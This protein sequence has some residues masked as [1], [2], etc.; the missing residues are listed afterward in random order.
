M[1]ETV[2]DEDKEEDDESDSESDE[3]ISLDTGAFTRSSY[4]S[5]FE[6][7][8]DENIASQ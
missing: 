5:E 6:K 1:N 4:Y 3:P 7:K 8:R 2:Y